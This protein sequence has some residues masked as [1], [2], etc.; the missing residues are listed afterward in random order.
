MRSVLLSLNT[1]KY[2]QCQT[3]Y[4]YLEEPKFLTLSGIG[5]IV[6]A[7]KESD[8]KEYKLLK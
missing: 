4:V 2:L 3:K 8:K 6:T 5:L 7:A 1:D